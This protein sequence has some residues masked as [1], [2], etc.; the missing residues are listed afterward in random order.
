MKIMQPLILHDIKKEVF[1][2]TKK[3]ISF[4]QKHIFFI[5]FF[6]L[7]SST[8]NGAENLF[9]NEISNSIRP[10]KN[11]NIAKARYSPDGRY[12]AVCS[13]DSKTVKIFDAVTYKII[14]SLQGHTYGIGALAF[15]P[16]SDLL[17]SAGKD[18][19]V[20]IWN[21]QTGHRLRSL[22]GHNNQINDLA[23]SPSGE[24][25]ASASDDQTVRLWDVVTG[26]TVTLFKKYVAGIHNGHSNKV[27]S[28]T[29]NADGTKLISGGADYKIKVWDTTT[30]KLLNSFNGQMQSI[31]SL[32]VSPDGKYLVSAECHNWNDRQCH[33]GIR[34]TDNWNLVNKIQNSKTTQSVYDLSFH[35]SGSFFLTASINHWISFWNLK[36]KRMSRINSFQNFSSQFNPEGNAVLS[37]S[38][39]Y[40]LTWDNKTG[41]LQRS[42]VMH[43]PISLSYDK[44]SKLLAAGSSNN[45]VYIWSD[46][47][48]KKYNCQGR[49]DSIRAIIFNPSGNF[50]IS[51]ENHR[52]N[53]RTCYIGIRKTK[54]WQNIAS[55]QA[56]LRGTMYDISFHPDEN[57]FATACY[58]H[59][60]KIWNING[61]ILRTLKSHQNNVRTVDFS[62]F[63]KYLVSGASDRAVK[64]WD[65]QTWKLVETFGEHKEGVTK[66][67]FSPD[68]RF[69]VTASSDGVV[70]L[71]NF[72]KRKIV[73]TFK[74]SG[75]PGRSVIFSPDTRY[76]II[77][78]G[79]GVKIYEI[80]SGEEKG[81]M[82]FSGT[83]NDLLMIGNKLFVASTSGV[84]EWNFSLIIKLHKQ[85][86][87]IAAPDLPPFA[88]AEVSLTSSS[89]VAGDNLE[90]DVTVH[91]NGKGALYRL[92][93][94]IDAPDLPSL[95]G[96]VI[97][98]G[99]VLPGKSKVKTAK[100]PISSNQ[101][102]IQTKF[103]INF[104]E[105]NDYVPDSITALV[106]VVQ[107][108][109][110]AVTRKLLASQLSPEQ[111]IDF[112]NGKKIS[113][114]NFEKY[115]WNNPVTFG[116]LINT[117]ENGMV[118]PQFLHEYI[119]NR[120]L[121]ANEV[122]DLINYGKLTQKTVTKVYI[123][124]PEFFNPIQ[125]KKLKA[126]KLIRPL[127]ISYAYQIKDDGS[128]N[129]VGNGD[130]RIQTGEAI[131]VYFTIKNSNDF[132]VRNV[133]IFITPSKMKGIRIFNKKKILG[134]FQPEEVKNARFTISI[135]KRVKASE[136]ALNFKL[137]EKNFLTV[138]DVDLAFPMDTRISPKVIAF[139]KVLKTTK[140][141]DVYSG[142]GKNTTIIAH[143]NKDTELVGAGELDQWYKI[144]LGEN[145][146]GWILKSN[147]SI[148]P[149][150][151]ALVHKPEIEKTDYSN[152]GYKVP[153][154]KKVN[155]VTS[156]TKTQ[157]VYKTRI[158]EK[159]R[160]K[161]I[162]VYQN[163]PPVIQIIT[164]SI[165]GNETLQVKKNRLQLQAVAFDETALQS[166]KVFVNGQI[167]QTGRGVGVI[168][169]QS[170]DARTQKLQISINLVKGTN[171]I[172]LQAMD[173]DGLETESNFNIERQIETGNVY[174][175]VIGIDQY[176]NGT[177]PSLRY[178]V[179]DANSFYNY[180]KNNLGIPEKNIHF[181]KNRQATTKNIK[182][183]MGDELK[184]K[185]TK[186]DTV[187]I[188][189]AG[190]GGIE[191]DTN[192]LDGDGFEKYLFP[193]D[194]HPYKLYSTALPMR[195]IK[196]IFGRIQADR[197]IF[198]ADTCYSGGSGGRT[199]TR[200]GGTRAR[201][202][203][204]FLQRLAEGKG[205]VILAASRANEVSH[206]SEK[207]GH[208]VFT[209]FL[210]DG[211]KG[212]ADLDKDT[213]ITI[214]EITSYV[215]K[216]VPAATKRNQ[217][218]VKKGEY[219]GEIII[220]Q[221][222]KSPVVSLQ[223]TRTIPKKTQNNNLYSSR[224]SKYNFPCQEWNQFPEQQR[225][226]KRNILKSLNNWASAWSAM[227]ANSYLS[228]YSRYF[229]P[230][231]NM[232]R[233]KWERQRRKR[234][235]KPYIH[236]H[237]SNFNVKFQSCKKGRVY[238]DQKY[239]TKN[240]KDRTRKVTTFV[241]ENDDW[242]IIEETT[243]E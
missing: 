95:N 169:Q 192:S 73:N 8:L 14:Y 48:E 82:A 116:F 125:I 63:G 153:E 141:S 242:K 226:E 143:V 69:I 109:E 57:Y 112:Y 115:L 35:P 64:L 40:L 106:S 54:N 7:I 139:Q 50:L 60:V 197:V 12:I 79:H 62:P 101:K 215:M 17:A 30:G 92:M 165:V 173:V 154:P 185:A 142:A 9:Y 225:I 224:S 205:R 70:H 219:E 213:Y 33:I 159:V 120:K 129:S 16:E 104:F 110:G 91:N 186:E 18:S 235:K 75:S 208:G 78:H 45:N 31:R 5:I 102:D 184:S 20:I 72:R 133:Q 171:Q 145:D 167:V 193:Y 156:K 10:F 243:I 38:S 34:K 68:E 86:W 187:Y 47:G 168:G 230:P 49:S 44:K 138:H 202:S 210:L 3:K 198:I 228:M 77:G 53:D 11:G 131:D 108:N 81:K 179:E 199:F 55:D 177:I 151:I 152:Q 89:V 85:P 52:W 157:V 241:K 126:K 27:L 223:K 183:L 232:S 130:G 121:N 163:A 204:A 46:D 76:L 100:F 103:N 118:S 229:I 28:L 172:V 206:E 43:N 195:E 96:Q 119:I 21:V 94:S 99:K 127:S 137:T 124:Y 41:K 2:K 164:P 207:L 111:I 113:R 88:E 227:D 15:S 194:A 236:V 240:Y 83:V 150:N 191:P 217:T 1:V 176:S 67:L 209:Y 178:A 233:K 93:A 132:P 161:I 162:P 128:G 160:E 203:D 97:V 37:G 26:K 19:T 13:W 61:S 182:W 42:F 149:E 158:I 59:S 239:E 216:K 218:P 201:I 105:G 181:L 87:E 51:L 144:D 122:M 65:T 84:T 23:F 29:F 140:D 166:F 180:L 4:L 136:L 6:I 135:K 175:A 212:K 148:I 117:I 107:L 146:A 238:F 222:M 90:M 170:I 190:H 36:G 74:A 220:G 234:L 189:F 58:D 24:F 134:D 214:D 211:L 155:S 174:A 123:T 71:R 98:F 221:T 188:Y 114:K 237:V 200:R 196:D 22:S 39:N 66:V 147:T 80:V 56:K 32:S 231:K 25:V